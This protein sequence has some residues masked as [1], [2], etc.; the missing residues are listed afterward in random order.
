MAV[1]TVITMLMIRLQNMFLFSAII[2][3]IL[4]FVVK[5]GG[6]HFPE[7]NPPPF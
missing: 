3:K 7:G 4:G 6:A 5:G 2:V 1:S